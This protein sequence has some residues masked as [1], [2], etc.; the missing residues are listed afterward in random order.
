M[1]T[2]ERLSE[3]GARLEQG[4]VESLRSFLAD[5]YFTAKPGPG[6]P[7]ARDR[8]TDLAVALKMALPDLS[9]SLRD[10][11]EGDDGSVT[12]SMTLRGTHHADLW[13]APGSGRVI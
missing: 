9:V 5:E 3:L 13:G 8:I 4:D 6:E 10:V 1:S 11:A 2:A 7:S 12:G